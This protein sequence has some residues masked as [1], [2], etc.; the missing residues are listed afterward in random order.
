MYWDLDLQRLHRYLQEDTP[1]L[2][3]FEAFVLQILEAE[4]SDR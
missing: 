4:A 3:Q 1:I 2:H